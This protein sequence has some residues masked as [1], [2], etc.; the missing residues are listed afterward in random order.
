MKHKKTGPFRGRFFY[1]GTKVSVRFG[2]GRAMILIFVRITLG[3]VFAVLLMGGLL[4][5]TALTTRLTAVFI[6]ALA[7]LL[8]FVPLLLALLGGLVHG[9][10]NTEIM[11]RVLE[12][13]FCKNAVASSGRVASQLEILL[14]QLL[15][16]T[17]DPQIGPVTVK[18]MV[19]VQRCLGTAAAA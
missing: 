16:R 11:F 10:E 15:R 8:T 7:L 3:S 14:E 12:I 2:L 17:T 6:G 9:V 18:H 5:F 4:V 19:A 1:V 13:G